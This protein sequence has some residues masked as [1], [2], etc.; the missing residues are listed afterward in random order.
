MTRQPRRLSKMLL[1]GSGRHSPVTT[2][3]HRLPEA[4]IEAGGYAL[5]KLQREFERELALLSAQMQAVVARYQSELLELKVAIRD[6]VSHRL[7]SL[8]DG[9]E[10]PVGA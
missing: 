4:L 9:K 8:Q 6:D 3:E 1:N 7:A 2:T 10:G 5:S